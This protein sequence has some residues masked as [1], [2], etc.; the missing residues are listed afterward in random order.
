MSTLQPFFNCAMVKNDHTMMFPPPNLTAD[1]VFSG[2]YAVSFDLQTWCVLQQAESSV[3]VLTRLY[4]PSISQVCLNVVQQAFN[5]LFLSSFSVLHGE[6]AHKVVEVLTV[7]F[8]FCNNKVPK[9]LK[10]LI[11]F[12]HHETLVT[13]YLIKAITWD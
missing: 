7:L 11:G 3:L 5:L 2:C 4:S 1:M 12:A 8:L 9:I 6:H 13:R 10:V